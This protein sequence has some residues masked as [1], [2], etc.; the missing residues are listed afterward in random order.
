MADFSFS[1]FQLSIYGYFGFCPWF[2]QQQTEAIPSF[3]FI[4]TILNP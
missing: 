2:Q 1:P 3:V 4:E